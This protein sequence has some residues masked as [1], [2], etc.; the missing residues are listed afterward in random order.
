MAGHR[1]GGLFSLGLL[2]GIF[3]GWGGSAAE[4]TVAATID[5]SS[6]TMQVYVDGKKRY[7]WR[8]STGKS[9]W[10]TPTGTFTPQQTYKSVYSKRFNMN[11]PHLVAITSNI[12]IH[13][14][15]AVG[16]LGSRAS[17]GCIRLAPGN[18][19]TFYKLVNSHGLWGTSVR[20]QY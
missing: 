15:G 20:V 1:I 2:A 11:L 17:H 7:T 8:V 14:T 3:A 19:A 5:I 6:Q 12:G 18:A 10:E 16:R 4:A 13:G 9:G